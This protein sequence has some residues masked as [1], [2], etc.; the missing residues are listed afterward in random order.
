MD[1]FVRLA[2][3]M[4][5]RLSIDDTAEQQ[6]A[7]LRRDGVLILENVLPAKCVAELNDELAPWF[8]KTP[9]GEGPFFGRTTKRF[10]AVMCKAKA[11]IDLIMH[12]RILSLCERV[13]I[14]D[15]IGPPRCDR[16][17]LNLTQAISIGPNEPEQVVH[18][19]QQLF[20]VTPG[21]ELLVNA[22]F[23]LDDFTFENGGT[24]FVPGSCAW[25]LDRWP[26]PH[27]I[28][29]AEAKAGSVIL[30][31][32]SMMH[33]GGENLTSRARRGLIVSYNLGWLAQ[34]ERLLLSAP[35]AIV[36]TLPERLQHLIGY[37]VHRPNLG[38]VEGRDPKQ[39][40][41]AG[42]VLEV[43][44][45]QDHLHVGHAT[46]VEGYYAQRPLARGA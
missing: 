17:Q 42:G 40:L 1:G 35:Q 45:A 34:T 33:G 41:D 12:E 20:W 28:A 39:W 22:M 23:C 44:G 21:Y 32:G 26:E 3:P 30:W 18:R 9:Y 24:R 46:L 13:L 16:I 37:Q 15:D 4:L 10:S 11:T 5:A 8:E 7:T 19:D 2:E 31:L 27:D 36:R 29:A 14:A 6:L 38:W 25:E 43:A